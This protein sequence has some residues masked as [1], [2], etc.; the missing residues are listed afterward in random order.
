MSSVHVQIKFISRS[1][2]DALGKV[3]LR[4]DTEEEEQAG[5]LYGHVSFVLIGRLFLMLVGFEN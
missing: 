5:D 3:D 4:G 2:L 1:N